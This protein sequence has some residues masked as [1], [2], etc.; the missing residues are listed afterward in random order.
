MICIGGRRWR[1]PLAYRRKK[2]DTADSRDRD[3]A[4]DTGTQQA[5]APPLG[6]VRGD[7]DL[8][9]LHRAL[10]LHSGGVDHGHQVIVK[11]RRHIDGVG[12]SLS[13]THRRP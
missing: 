13:V 4:G 2:K 6:N 1:L 3:Q 5:N 9:V 11:R 12:G 7:V 8:V 10:V